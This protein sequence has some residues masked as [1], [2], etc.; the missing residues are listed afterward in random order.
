L[1]EEEQLKEWVPKIAKLEQRTEK[2]FVSMNN[3]Y[4]AQAVINGRMLKEML[5]KGT[6]VPDR[7]EAAQ[8]EVVT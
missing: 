4:R 3:H 5:E 2:T 7:T 1:Y 8:E 6:T